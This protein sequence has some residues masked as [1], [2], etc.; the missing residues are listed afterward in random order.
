MRFFPTRSFADAGRLTALSVLLAI[1]S[2]C[3]LFSGGDLE[4]TNQPS[5]SHGGTLQNRIAVAPF[6]VQ[7][8]HTDPYTDELMQSYLMSAIRDEC[9]GVVF[10]KPADRDYPAVLRNLPQLASGEMDNLQAAV[11]GR[12]LGISAIMVGTLTSVGTEEKE[13]GIWLLKKNQHYVRVQVL[14]EL[15]DTETATKLL[16]EAAVHEIEIEAI[17]AAMIE[18]KDHVD[19]GFVEEVLELIA[20]KVDDNICDAIGEQDWKSYVLSAASDGLWIAAGSQSGL[21]PGLVLEVFDSNT[22]MDGFGGH[23]YFKP[24]PKI[25]EIE[26]VEVETHRSRAV[27]VN[28]GDIEPLSA[29]KMKK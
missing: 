13:R 8:Q 10:V 11:A 21:R 14:F 17:D 12:Q 6:I 2:A 24:G 16:D 9:P 18:Q 25:G 29:V 23:K 1:F 19:S 7:S 27:R 5:R 22:V 15:Y 20:E 26:V 4:S 3:S 28:G